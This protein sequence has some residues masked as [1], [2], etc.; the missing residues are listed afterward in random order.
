MKQLKPFKNIVIFTA[1]L[2]LACLTACGKEDSAGTDSDTVVLTLAAPGNLTLKVVTADGSAVK[3]KGCSRSKIIG[4]SIQNL[5]ASGTKVELSGSITA[6]YSY[7]NNLTNLSL[8]SQY[9]EKLDCSHNEIKIIDLKNCPKLKILDCQFNEITRLNLEGCPNLKIVDCYNNKLRSINIAGVTALENLNC[10]NN[11]LDASAFT[12]IFENLPRRNPG[13]KAK[14][15]LYKDNSYEKNCQNFNRP[16]SL[17]NSFDSAKGTKNWT[18]VY[19]N[20]S[21][22]EIE[23]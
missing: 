15:V 23:I 9:I 17:K 10:Y 3:V 22:Q 16:K 21:F 11:E 14:C 19:D 8:N 13:E 20:A 18:M 12:A 5:K 4:D 1:A 6:L 2:I 7:N